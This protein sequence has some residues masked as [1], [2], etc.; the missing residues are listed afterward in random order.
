MNTS[1]KIVAALVSVVSLAGIGTYAAADGKKNSDPLA[2]TQV[3]IS[4]DQAVN[5][6]LQSVPGTVR[7]TDF[8]NDNDNE[9]MLWDIEIIDS[10]GQAFDVEINANTG[11]VMSQKVADVDVDG[12]DDDDDDD[13]DYDHDQGG[14]NENEGPQNE[15]NSQN[16]K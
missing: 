13:D 8:D 4:Q 2:V 5:I 14:N 15:Q 6:A 7:S 16:K 3:P 9:G 10:T 12:D 11:D 1:R